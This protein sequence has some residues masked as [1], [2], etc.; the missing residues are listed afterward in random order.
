MMAL[1]AAALLPLLGGTTSTS[2][3]AACEV[4]SSPST[5]VFPNFAIALP[6]PT[7]S[8]CCAL[9]AA[10]PN[11]YAGVQYKG[12]CWIKNATWANGTKAELCQRSPDP[13]PGGV[14]VRP[15]R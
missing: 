1:A 4:V 15:R 10:R 14:S 2:T 13:N 11:C 9:C 8:S 3:P 7:T 5:D 12:Q 6:S